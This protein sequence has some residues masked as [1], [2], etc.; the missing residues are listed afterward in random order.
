MRERLDKVIKQRRLIRSRARAQRMIQAG[1]V[2][3]NGK[4]VLRPGHR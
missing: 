1:R 3:V 2:T 4:I